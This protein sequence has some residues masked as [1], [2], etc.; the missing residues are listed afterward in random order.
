MSNVRK[1]SGPQ[2]IGSILGDVLESSGLG[3]RLRDRAVLNDWPAVVGAAA[4]EH[5][6]PLDLTDGIMTL[7]ADHAAWRQELTLLAPIIIRKFNERHGDGTVRSLR[8]SHG[9]T[10]HHR[11]D[12][13]A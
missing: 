4:A 8:W 2:L 12:H 13:Q 9:S 11:N 7:E 3:S 5:A 1:K 10:R 6:R